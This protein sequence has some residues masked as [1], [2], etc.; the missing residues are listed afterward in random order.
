MWLQ[1]VVRI[2]DKD[3]GQAPLLWWLSDC[4]YLGLSRCLWQDCPGAG[5]SQVLGETGMLV[6]WV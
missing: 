2:V 3:L 1:Y 5:H 4:I 6:C